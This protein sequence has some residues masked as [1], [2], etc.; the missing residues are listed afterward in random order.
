MKERK[1]LRSRQVHEI[2]SSIT[3]PKKQQTD[4]ADFSSQP[5]DYET[6][7][8]DVEDE[9]C[10][11]KKATR[12]EIEHIKNILQKVVIHHLSSRHFEIRLLGLDI[13][14]KG[15]WALVSDPGNLLP[16]V[17]NVWEALKPRFIDED[18]RVLTKALGVMRTLSIVS[19]EFLARKFSEDLWPYLKTK[20]RNSMSKQK[21]AVNLL[22]QSI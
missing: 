7:A 18:P 13:I 2:S 20:L 12:K 21:K 22:P 3:I 16:T 17:H 9:E 5:S 11:A 4:V 8:E 14:E 1:S 10:E 19:K 15:I 6:R